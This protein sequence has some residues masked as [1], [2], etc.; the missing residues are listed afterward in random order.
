LFLFRESQF[1]SFLHW[2]HTLTAL[3]TG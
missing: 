1:Y 3:A 2:L